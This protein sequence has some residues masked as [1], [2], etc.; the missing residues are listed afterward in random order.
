MVAKCYLCEKGC[1]KNK[2]IVLHRFPKSCLHTYQQWLNACG[3][4]ERDNV[5]NVYICTRHFESSVFRIKN[6]RLRLH[7]GAVPT[8]D[9]LNP[10][11][12]PVVKEEKIEN[13][14]T[15]TNI[16]PKTLADSITI[17]YKREEQLT[18]QNSNIDTENNEYDIKEQS[19]LQTPDSEEPDPLQLDIPDIDYKIEEQLTS[20]NS[21]IGNCIFQ[22]IFFI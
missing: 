1:N 4:N 12:K 3:L 7:R 19:I 14:A 9:V 6:T 10:V 8:I 5:S 17:D 2:N 22:L 13:D 18:S 11:L 21:N 15:A 16:F 20:Q